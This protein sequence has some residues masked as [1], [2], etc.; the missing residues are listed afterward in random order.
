VPARIEDYAIIGDT[1]TVALVDRHGSIDWWCAPR[2]D[3]G[4]A[5]AALLGTKDNGRWLIAPKEPVLSVSRSYEKETLVLETVFETASG[6]AAV[7]DFMPPYYTDPT[8]HRIVEG[9]DGTVEM[10][11]ELIVRFEYG[12]ITPWVTANGDGLVMVAGSDGLRLHSPVSLTGKGHTTTATFEV[13][14][15]ARRSFSLTWFPSTGPTPLPLDSLAA[16]SHARGWWRD[17]VSRCTYDG[18]WRDDVVRSLITLKALTY[19]PSGAV[20][21]AATTSLPEELGGARNWDYRYSWLRDATFTL[22]AFLLSGYTDEAAAW[23]RWLRRAVAGSPGELQIMYGV[24]G[25]R[26]LTEFELDAL[27][28]YE[29]SRPVRIGNQAS[30]QFQLDVFGEVLD[31]ALTA[32]RNGF[33]REVDWASDLL[34]AN[35]DHLEQVWDQPDDGIWEMRGPRRH[36]THSKVMAWVAFDRAI[37]LAQDYHTLPGDRVA[38]WTQLRDRVHAQVCAKGFD[39]D[40]NSFTQYY[41]STVLDASL[42]M[43]APVGFLPPDDPRIVGT[44]AAI[45]KDLVEDGFVRRY[46]L[47]GSTDGLPGTEGTFLMTTF[48]LADNLALMG[49]VDEAREIF[50]RLRGLSN[51][52]GLLSEEYDPSAGRMLGNFPQAFSHVSLINTAANLS[53]PQ[54]PSLMR[55]GRAAVHPRRKR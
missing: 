4:A 52:V 25:E 35:L 2:I 41:G 24:G 9:R 46:Q 12:A 54:G 49:R 43:L 26:R 38:R 14:P 21:A 44:V 27:P 32:A 3:S 34:L 30:T 29:G 31:S 18:E 28:G 48:W 37:R 1:R 17:W 19:E 23:T 40:I 22:A 10:E 15:D 53:T 51:D 16:R 50:E 8:V 13:A 42:L 11:M 6:R 47:D 5:F 55:S 45:Q 36:F 39:K 33:P 20:C 7:I